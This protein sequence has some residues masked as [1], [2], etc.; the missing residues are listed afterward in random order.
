MP[1]PK[2]VRCRG[3]DR[4]IDEC[5]PLSARKLCEDCGVAG[6]EQAVEQMFTGRGAIYER[7]AANTAAGVARAVEKARARDDG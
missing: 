4:H 6:I 3:C 1:R 2:R 7:W 5:G